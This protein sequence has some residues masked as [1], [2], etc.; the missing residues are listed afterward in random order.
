MKWR[1][2]RLTR[3][4]ACDLFEQHVLPT[5]DVSELRGKDLLCHCVPLRCHC[6]PILRKANYDQEESSQ[7]GHQEVGSAKGSGSKA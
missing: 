7:E 6:T 1:G 5:L 3:D 2:K 4:M